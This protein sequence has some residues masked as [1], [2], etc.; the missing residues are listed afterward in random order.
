[1]KKITL[2]LSFTLFIHTL[3]A[4]IPD[5]CQWAY[6]PVGTNTF[7][8]RVINSA[9]DLQGNIVE[10]GTI[11]GVADMDPG[12]AV[13]DTTFSLPGYNYYLSETAAD[14][15]LVWIKYFKGFPAV[16]VFS[17]NGV[18]VNS[19]NEIIVVGSYFGVIDFDLS[20]SGVDTIR[21]RQPTYQDYFVAK[22]DS[23]GN[24]LWAF[25]IGDVTNRT[26]IQTVSLQPNDDILVATN[27]NGPVDVDPGVGIH[28]SL[29]GNAN[30]VCY[31]SNGNYNWVNNI[32]VNYSYAEN[33]K[34]L[35]GDAAGNIY[36]LSLGYYELTVNKF[37]SN[38]VRLWNKT[39]GLFSA[40][41]R[42]TPQSVL[43]DKLNGNFY[44]AGTFDGTVDFDPGPNSV[45]QTSNNISFE[46]GF[47]A[48]YDS[49]MG[50]L[51]VNAYP[52]N[53]EFGKYSMDFY[54]TDILL[55]GS[56]TGSID[57]GNGFTFTSGGMTPFLLKI[58][59]SGSTTD[60]FQLN[61]SGSFNTLHVES[62]LSLVTTGAIFTTMDMDPGAAT[63]TLTVPN[64]SSFTAVYSLLT[65][66]NTIQGSSAS[67]QLFPNTSS[68]IFTIN[69]EKSNFSTIKIY[70]ITGEL[71]YQSIANKKTV[72]DLSEEGRG[73]YFV[74]ILN[75]D[76]EVANRKVIV[77]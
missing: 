52:G 24:Y 20:D 36:L 2:F 64:A 46:D 76:G 8:A 53:V 3:F 61:G 41:A 13:S 65:S 19:Q 17:F 37:N 34:S 15:R 67:I 32:A 6:V 71:I 77:E 25:S 63:L 12:T 14:G 54:G 47:I 66:V 40:G 58:D 27:T 43:V 62:T 60:A 1:M 48:K 33:Y 23:S 22:Y 29:G 16:S 11:Y 68:G 42:V 45:T 39:I 4:Q 35:E 73:M 10:T 26:Q 21:S 56:Y 7:N 69:T 70:N 38:G 49:S 51:W 57:F 59:G 44:V 72:V 5:N 75:E 31:D 30:L 9:I 74:T 55:G 18:K 28:N 50:L